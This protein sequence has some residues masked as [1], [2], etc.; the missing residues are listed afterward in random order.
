MLGA[1]TGHVHSRE[2]GKYKIKWEKG[3]T[4]WAENYTF[5]YGEWNADNQLG[6]GFLGHKRS[7]S[8]VRRTEF[9]S[10][11]MPHIKLIGR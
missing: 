9:V 8:A 7:M 5:F 1:F 11:R 3:G 2:L 6:T 4:E 10:N